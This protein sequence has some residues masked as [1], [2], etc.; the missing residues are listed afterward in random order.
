MLAKVYVW[1]IECFFFLF[2]FLKM[3]GWVL[4]RGDD[5]EHFPFDRGCGATILSCVNL[6]SILYGFCYL[7]HPYTIMTQIKVAHLLTTHF[8][9]WVHSINQNI[10]VALNSPHPPLTHL[11]QIGMLSLFRMESLPLSLID[12]GGVNSEWIEL[13]IKI[14]T[15]LAR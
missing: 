2:F 1:M 15:R 14:H 12:V 4:K 3:N 8:V 6:V 11:L 10:T 9:W 13:S 7:S 5:L